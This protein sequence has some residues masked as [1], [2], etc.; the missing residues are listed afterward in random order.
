MCGETTRAIVSNPA[1]AGEEKPS[2]RSPG[3]N[4]MPDPWATLSA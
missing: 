1:Q 2:T 3:L 4:T